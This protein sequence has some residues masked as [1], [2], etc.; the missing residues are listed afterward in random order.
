MLGFGFLHSHPHLRPSPGIKGGKGEGLSGGEPGGGSKLHFR[1]RWGG[2]T[3]AVGF[4]GKTAPHFW[5][6]GLGQILSEPVLSIRTSRSW[7]LAP[8]SISARWPTPGSKRAGAPRALSPSLLSPV[9]LLSSQPHSSYRRK[10]AK[11]L[12]FPISV[13]C[14]SLSSASPPSFASD[15]PSN[16]L[17]ML[18]PCFLGFACVRRKDLIIPD[19]SCVSYH[20]ISGLEIFPS[21]L[22]EASPSG[23]SL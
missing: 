1:W 22:S 10:Y 6:A 16:V 23:A 8:L 20:R 11:I 17:V 21:F 5:T 3:A 2:E 4:S 7:Q 18:F 12:R 14:P 9:R 13:P 19:L 15:S